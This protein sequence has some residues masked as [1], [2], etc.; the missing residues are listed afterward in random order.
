MIAKALVLYGD[1]INCDLETEYGLSIAGFS[2]ERI[3]ATELLKTPGK[4]SEC[5]MLVLP[6]GF[7]FGDEIASG[8][9]LS[10]ELKQRISAA[11]HE[12]IDKKGLVIGICNGF[13]ILVQLGI[14]PVSKSGAQ[15]VVSLARNSGGKFINRWV[16]LSVVNE[17]QS[18]FFAGLKEIDLP[19]RHGEGRLTLGVNP[20]KE[21]SELVSKHTVLRYRDDV[22]G[23]YEK[24]A[25][26]TN[27]QGNVLGL[28]P[29][30]EA[31]IRWSQHP[32]WTDSKK[33]PSE[34]PH[35]LVILQN[36]RKALG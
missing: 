23:S 33:E 16:N 7:S 20:G 32:S 1:G 8:K 9:V 2:P 12:F 36:A 11:L 14:L 29:H 17:H 13:Q 15:K 27:E 22:N 26:L 31:F 30:P 28:M 3:H 10:I 24:A 19:I 34:T 18:P 6:G 5:Q 25:A 4:L 21:V 35:G